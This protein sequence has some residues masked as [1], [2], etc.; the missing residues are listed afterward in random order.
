VKDILGSLP[1][2]SPPKWDQEFYVNPSVDIEAIGV[3]LLQK[4]PT[5]SLMRPIYFVSRVVKPTKQG[6]T[7]IEANGVGSNV[8]NK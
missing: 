7:P 2:I 4:D 1:I 5:T 8:Y 3:V 6:Y